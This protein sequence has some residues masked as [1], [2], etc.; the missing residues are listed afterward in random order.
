MLEGFQ[1][2]RTIDRSSRFKSIPAGRIHICTHSLRD[3][4]ETNRCLPKF[5][6]NI[7]LC[8]YCQYLRSCNLRSRIYIPQL[9]VGLSII[10]PSLNLDVCSTSNPLKGPILRLVPHS[11]CQEHINEHSASQYSRECD[12]DCSRLRHTSTRLAAMRCTHEFRL[13]TRFTRNVLVGL[14]A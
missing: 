4:R 2:V 8:W 1:S 9:F 3:C 13:V 10:S 14:A 7:Y 5:L 11:L 6:I 12:H